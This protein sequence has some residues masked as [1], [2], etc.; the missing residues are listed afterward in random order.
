MIMFGRFIHLYG[1]VHHFAVI[2][3]R[4]ARITPP[5][6]ADKLLRQAMG[7]YIGKADESDFLAA[8]LWTREGIIARAIATT[9]EKC[10]EEIST[11][12]RSTW[13]RIK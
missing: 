12:V 8:L 4:E 5:K 3:D 11:E 6:F 7:D 1:V 13:E 10:R 2:I 9:A